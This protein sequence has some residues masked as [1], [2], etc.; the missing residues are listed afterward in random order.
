M[1]LE[2]MLK[3]V[4]SEYYIQES[5]E[6]KAYKSADK[7]Y[8]NLLKKY[9][10]KERVNRLKINSKHNE[11][12]VTEEHIQLLKFINEIYNISPNDRKNPSSEKL[13]LD[14]LNTVATTVEKIIN[15][16]KYPAINDKLKTTLRTPEF[17]SLHSM[18]DLVK[19][20][21]LLFQYVCS[22]N[23]SDFNVYNQVNEYL[24]A[25][26]YTYVGHEHYS[27]FMNEVY[28]KPLEIK[29]PHESDNKIEFND[30]SIYRGIKKYVQKIFDAVTTGD[31]KSN[32]IEADLIQG[33]YRY[34]FEFDSV[35]EIVEFIGE[36]CKYFDVSYKFQKYCNRNLIHRE[37]SL[38]EKLSSKY[39]E[40]AFSPYLCNEIMNKT[41]DL[42]HIDKE[43]KQKLINDI[44]EK[45]EFDIKL[46][47]EYTKFDGG[48]RNDLKNL[49]KKLRKAQDEFIN[50]YMYTYGNGR[51]LRA[52][53]FINTLKE[54]AFDPIKTSFNDFEFEIIEAL[55]YD[56]FI[57]PR[58][59]SFFDYAKENEFLSESVD[60][61]KFQTVEFQLSYKSFKIQLSNVD[62][63]KEQNKKISN[64][65]IVDGISNV[66]KKIDNQITS[67]FKEDNE[68]YSDIGNAVGIYLN[69]IF[70]KSE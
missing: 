55:F 58:H 49:C 25:L 38:S 6:K 18:H 10:L 37:K 44:N 5:D 9:G 66:L 59:D 48:I 54:K 1:K 40:A 65:E 64:K 26:L 23:Y 61:T 12:N 63:I 33:E 36:Y 62:A 2:E 17:L 47:Q 43:E 24:D 53:R 22:S 30:I 68:L 35:E 39:I 21:T 3:E 15:D 28:Y 11:Y 14:N 32:S 19:K 60:S 41:T 34:V 51:L 13:T 67:N 57:I 56:G 52:I 50:K 70:E 42:L 16:E 27:D 4:F 20:I 45:I 31:S 7:S 8:N 29:M 69:K 46:M